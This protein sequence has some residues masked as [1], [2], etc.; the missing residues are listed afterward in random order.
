M[1]KADVEGDSVP[2]VVLSELGVHSGIEDDMGL[3]VEL[4]P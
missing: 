4:E 1:I 2:L 3:V